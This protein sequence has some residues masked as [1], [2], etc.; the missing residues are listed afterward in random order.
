MTV[1]DTDVVSVSLRIHHL[2]LACVVSRIF[3]IFHLQK[4]PTVLVFILTTYLGKPQHRQGIM[5]APSPLTISFSITP[6]P[7]LLEDDQIRDHLIATD[8]ELGS[9]EEL[10]LSSLIHAIPLGSRNLDNTEELSESTAAPSAENDGQLATDV[11]DTA[12]PN[13]MSVPAPGASRPVF[14]W[15]SEA[16]CLVVAIAALTA[17]VVVLAKFDKQEQPHWPYADLLNLSALVAILATLLTSMITL[18]LE[19]GK[20]KFSLTQCR[21]YIYT[22]RQ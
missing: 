6:T 14:P 16:G 1:C 17:T 20:Y 19:A 22:Q 9:L 10:E 5:E 2:T 7:S 4:Y 18:I 12:M 15:L 11:D 3:K 8:P 13:E 21:L